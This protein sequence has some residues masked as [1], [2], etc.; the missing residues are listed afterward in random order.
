MWLTRDAPVLSSLSE[1]PRFASVH[2]SGVR[3]VRKGVR[4]STQHILNTAVTLCSAQAL[5]LPGPG[6]VLDSLHNP[7]PGRVL[8]SLHNPAPTQQNE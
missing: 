3:A 1:Q 6:S 5:H 4:L 7:G 2:S 8:D